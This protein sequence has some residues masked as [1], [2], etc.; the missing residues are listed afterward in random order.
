MPD[1]VV[2][3]PVVETP[4]VETPAVETPAPEPDSVPGGLEDAP[5]LTAEEVFN[6]DPFV[7]GNVPNVPESAIGVTDDGTVPETP[8]AVVAA[9]VVTP[10]TP[11]PPPVQTGPTYEQVLEQNRVLSEQNRQILEML[12]KGQTPQP[13]TPAAPAE[14]TTPEYMFEIPQQIWTMIQSDDPA[15]AQRGL[16]AL[17]AG[18]GKT[19]HQHV[20]QEYEGKLREAIQNARQTFATDTQRAATATQVYNDF[21]GTYPQFNRPELRE[22]VAAAT[23]AVVKET[24]AT[25]WSAGLRDQI[26][27]R[28]SSIISSVTGAPQNVQV[29]P[30]AGTPPAPPAAVRARPN[31]PPKMRGTSARPVPEAAPVPGSQEAH[32]HDVIHGVN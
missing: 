20:R 7:D 15:Q 18:M 3:T 16:A 11:P 22:L 19:V 14:P 31:T 28:V 27:E 17:I 8:A 10:P 29:T 30:P 12:A 4:A 9:P 21:Y 26:G 1:D 2:E 25:Q 13:A 23:N 6:F 24:Q 32:M 5:N